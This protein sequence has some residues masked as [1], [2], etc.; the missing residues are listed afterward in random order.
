MYINAETFT[1]LTENRGVYSISGPS[2]DIILGDLKT[3]RDILFEMVDCFSQYSGYNMIFNYGS[4]P[5]YEIKSDSLG[6]YLIKVGNGLVK[7]RESDAQKFWMR[8]HALV[9]ITKEKNK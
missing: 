8:L 4:E 3:S 5:K 6:P 2:G 7:L 1:K 9:T